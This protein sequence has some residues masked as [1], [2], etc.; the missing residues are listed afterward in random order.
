LIQEQE[1]REDHVGEAKD[2][3]VARAGLPASS[4]RL[5]VR[6]PRAGRRPLVRGS[7]RRAYFPAPL[8]RRLRYRDDAP[9]P[10]ALFALRDFH[11]S[12]PHYEPRCLGQAAALSAAR[13]VG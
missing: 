4:W 9:G 3:L 8:W 2:Q 5:L 6:C 12:L 1:R 13:L 11:D 7:G 10:Q